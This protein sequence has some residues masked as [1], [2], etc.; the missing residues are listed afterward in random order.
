M[1]YKLGI[2]SQIGR[3]ELIVVNQTGSPRIVAIADKRGD[4]AAAGY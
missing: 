1:G 3:T 2:R 4:D